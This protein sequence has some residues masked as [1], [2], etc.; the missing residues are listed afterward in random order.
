MRTTNMTTEQC[1]RHSVSETSTIMKKN[2]NFFSFLRRAVA[3][4]P[5]NYYIKFARVEWFKFILCV[6]ESNKT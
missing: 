4:V 3:T 2:N 6:I 1:T 5:T